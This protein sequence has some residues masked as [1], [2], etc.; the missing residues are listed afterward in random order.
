MTAQAGFS[1]AFYI[2]NAMEIL[3]RIAWY[4]FFAVSSLYMSSSRASGG[5]GLSEAQRGVLQG[6]IP[7]FVYLLPVVT[8]ALGDRLGYRRL[9]FAAYFV[10]APSY[11]LLGQ[12]ASFWSFFGI[13]LLVALGAAIFKPLVVGTVAR[14]AT[15]ENRGRAFGIFYMMVN[16]GGFLG[17]VIAGV[18]RTLSWD[19]VFLLS[20]SV[21]ALNLLICFFFFPKDQHAPTSPGALS[22]SLRDAGQVIGN[23]RFGLLVIPMVFALMIAG[24]GWMSWPQ[25]LVAALSWVGINLFW[26]RLAQQERSTTWYRQRMRIGNGPFLVY[27]VTLT[28]F[29]AVYNQIFLT[30]PLYLRDFVDTSSLVRLAATVAPVLADGLAPVSLEQV[31]KLL[32]EFTAPGAVNADTALRR[33]IELQVRPPL[34]VVELGLAEVRSGAIAIE[35]LAQNWASAYRQVSPEYIISIDFLMI[36]LCQYAISSRIEGL[37]PFRILIAGTGLIGISYLLGGLAHAVPIGGFFVVGAAVLFAT[38]EMLASPKS[39][40]YVAAVM[41]QEKAAM[42]M[43]FYFVSLALGFLAAGILSGVLYQ[44]FAV[45]LER[46]FLMWAAFAALAVVAM[47]ALFAFDQTLAKRLSSGKNAP[48]QVP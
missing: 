9:F 43:G 10:L 31:N 40:E 16:V 23:V 5:L 1:R 7:F 34:E 29:W 27:I 17:P 2:A 28:L 37:A 38:G 24:G 20:S 44:R 14:S 30:M 4:G 19:Y 26:D 3:E 36:V 18:M 48:G 6:V 42:F 45:E 39:Q 47:L 12:M 35:A 11:Y 46:P 8:G 25:L 22:H 21:I 32:A 15:D 33:L 13:Y 41:P